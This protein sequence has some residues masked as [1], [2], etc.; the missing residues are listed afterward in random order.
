VSVAEPLLATPTLLQ[1]QVYDL[2]RRR[3]VACEP[4]YE[5]GS[6]LNMTQLAAELKISITPVKD[7]IRRLQADGLVETKPRQGIYVS[8]LSNEDLEH[9]VAVR[10]G[11]EMLAA[12]LF[13][14]PVDPAIVAGMEAELEAWL[15]ERRRGD[16]QAAYAHHIAFHQLVVAA[17]G[18]RFV[19]RLYEQLHAHVS[20]AFAYYT[21]SFNQTDDEVLR[22]RLVLDALV[23]GDREGVRRHVADH[24]RHGRPI[25]GPD[26]EIPLAPQE[27][28][29]ATPKRRTRDH[30]TKRGD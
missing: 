4:G 23:R 12:D 5:P 8:T 19:Q 27:T 16:V 20:I 2:L 17:C 3:I 25:I 11:L 18:N 1:L 28:G 10:R 13:V 26:G 22:H 9:L 14:P 6:Q 15:A 21:R 7:A 29:A 24:Y 30:T